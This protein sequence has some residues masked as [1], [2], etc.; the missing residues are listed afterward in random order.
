MSYEKIN[1][2]IE[3]GLFSREMCEIVNPPSL[4]EISNFSRKSGI[5]LSKEHID[6]LAQWG[7]SGLD[8]IRINGLEKIVFEN[9][10]TEFANDYNGFIYKYGMDGA[11]F[12]EDTDGGE[13][14]KLAKSVSDFINN[15]L[16][17]EPGE[18]FYG[19]E[20][21]AELREKGIA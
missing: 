8:E 6:L 1:E 18:F 19:K 21:V 17:G 16:L 4:E 12:T 5:Q 15:I 14:T 3:S 13:V 2:A 7:G 9:S 10:Y 11:V 20:W